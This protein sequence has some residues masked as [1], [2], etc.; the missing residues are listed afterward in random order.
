MIVIQCISSPVKSYFDKDIS[1][2]ENSDL[3]TVNTFSDS[4]SVIHLVIYITSEFKQTERN[5][6]SYIEL[7][8]HMTYYTAF[9]T[10]TK[11]LIDCFGI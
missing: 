2:L 3:L 8:E 4:F 11:R 10:G 1:K 6:C 5:R 9:T 7:Q